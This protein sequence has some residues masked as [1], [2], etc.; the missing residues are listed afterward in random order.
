MN[1]DAQT[2]IV[3][4]AARLLSDSKLLLDHDRCGTAFALAVLAMEEIGKAI[5][6]L[7]GNPQPSAKRSNAHLRKQGAVASVLV[8]HHIVLVLQEKMPEPG[9][10]VTDEFVEQIARAIWESN[11]GQFSAHVTM[12]V[13]DKTK[14]LAIYH[15]DWAAE[16]GLYSKPFSAADVKQIHDLC[17]QVVEAM[18]EKDVMHVGRAIYLADRDERARPLQ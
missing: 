3:T 8:A 13:I 1:E 6:N 17:R 11:S 18:G 2:P 7:W 12:G 15:D 10:P 14:Q 9:L 16:A 5:L 4:N